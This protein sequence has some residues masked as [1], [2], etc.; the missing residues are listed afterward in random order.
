MPPKPADAT[1]SPLNPENPH[2]PAQAIEEMHSA[3][4]PA[5]LALWFALAGYLAVFL[6]DKVAFDTHAMLGDDHGASDADA[7]LASHAPQATKGPGAIGAV[8]L[9]AALCVHS[10]FETLALGVSSSKTAATLL[11][12][13]IGLHQP[14]E[15]L[16]LLVALLKSGL[17]RSSIVKLLCIF[18]AMQPLGCALGLVARG[19]DVPMLDSAL[20]AVAAGTFIYVGCNE[21]VAEEFEGGTTS[22]RWKKFGSFL[23]GVGS[24]VLMT[25]VTEKWHAH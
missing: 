6:V 20:A 11:S 10:I 17:S 18:T 12:A 24:I 2:A 8:V 1:L 13:S 14:A 22:E 7:V 9:L 3:G 25:L 16:A 15:S 19:L 5:S 4:S 21:V 23:G